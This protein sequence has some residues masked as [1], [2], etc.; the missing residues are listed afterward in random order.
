MLPFGNERVTLIQ[1]IDI[2]INGKTSVR[3]SRHILNGC[4]WSESEAWRN[5]GAEMQRSTEIVCKIPF[6]QVQP[7][8]GDYL[9][10]GYMQ[11][12]IE[13]AHDINNALKEYRKSGAMRVASVSNR[14]LAGMP[15]PHITARGDSA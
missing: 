3:Y 5:V 2:L 15:I 9:F 12:L 6:D 8:P 14:A 4:S 7:N 13:D 11:D 10:R 1:R